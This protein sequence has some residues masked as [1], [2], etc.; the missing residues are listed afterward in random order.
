MITMIAVIFILCILLKPIIELGLGILALLL[1]TVGTAAF[2]LIKLAS[3][4]AL[5][6]YAPTLAVIVFIVYIFAGWNH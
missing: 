5:I 4:V 3:A 6:I 1:S 2:F